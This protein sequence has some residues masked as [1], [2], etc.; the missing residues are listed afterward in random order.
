MSLAR[1]GFFFF[2][3]CRHALV[4]EIGVATK[5]SA[6]VEEELDSDISHHG[7][8]RCLSSLESCM[9]QQLGRHSRDHCVSCFAIQDQR[10]QRTLVRL[11]RCRFWWLFKL[12]QI[13]ERMYMKTVS[14]QC[15]T[16]ETRERRVVVVRTGCMDLAA[17]ILEYTC[18]I[19]RNSSTLRSMPAVSFPGAAVA[20]GYKEY[21]GCFS[22]VLFAADE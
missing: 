10:R 13:L 17:K 19:F 6:K 7:Q 22:L 3:L 9:G 8:R 2:Y 18:R 4:V 11:D 16:R 14:Y 20:V 15:S 1:I 21:E 12:T 5:D